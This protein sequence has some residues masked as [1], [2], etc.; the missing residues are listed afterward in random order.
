M[1]LL[2]AECPLS[3]GGQDKGQEQGQSFM[4]VVEDRSGKL[5]EDGVME[6]SK[7]Y[8]WLLEISTK[9]SKSHTHPNST[10]QW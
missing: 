7:F 2:A 6:A 5:T 8:T 10:L 3:C 4:C 1:V 9:Q